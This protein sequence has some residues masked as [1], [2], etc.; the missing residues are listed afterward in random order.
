MRRDL[1]REIQYGEGE[2]VLNDVERIP[3]LQY[4]ILDWVKRDVLCIRENKCKE[5]ESVSVKDSAFSCFDALECLSHGQIKEEDSQGVE[6]DLHNGVLESVCDLRP[7]VDRIKVDWCVVD[8]G[9]K[10]G[11]GCKENYSCFVQ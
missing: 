9:P 3:C 11:N 2:Q 1:D 6:Y 5:R 7:S 10:V 4:D 8:Q